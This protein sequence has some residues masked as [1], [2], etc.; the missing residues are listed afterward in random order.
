MVPVK[1]IHGTLLGYVFAVGSNYAEA[2][3]PRGVRRVSRKHSLKARFTY[4]PNDADFLM[5]QCHP[6]TDTEG[7][8]SDATIGIMDFRGVGEDLACKTVFS[9][10]AHTIW[11]ECHGVILPSTFCRTHSS[12]AERDG[13]EQLQY[14][15]ELP[16]TAALQMIPSSKSP[17]GSSC[18]HRCTNVDPAFGSDTFGN[19]RLWRSED[20]LNM[21]VA[22][23]DG[24]TLSDCL[25]ENVR[26]DLLPDTSC[27]QVLPDEHSLP[28]RGA[29]PEPN[30][31]AQSRTMSHFAGQNETNP[32]LS[33]M[34]E[35]ERLIKGS[36]FSLASLEHAVSPGRTATSTR[37][38]GRAH[39]DRQSR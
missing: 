7:A 27:S 36:F 39:G 22:V 21:L 31:I 30:P 1:V 34:A 33:S 4:N 24:S 32:L 6:S 20:I 3:S 15:L 18:T 25:D 38:L 8:R 16:P 17:T 11:H 26:K 35:L 5:V 9:V 14:D 23:P 28:I 13:S 10:P 2:D 19:D 12:L 37:R 29:T